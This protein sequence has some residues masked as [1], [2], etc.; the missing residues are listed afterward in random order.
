MTMNTKHYNPMPEERPFVVNEPEA[1]Y[2]TKTSTLSFDEDFDRA[3]AT[4][5]TG[6]ELRKRLNKQIDSWP[7]EKLLSTQKK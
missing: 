5:I 1:V 2:E 7:W 6:D 4:A 3:L